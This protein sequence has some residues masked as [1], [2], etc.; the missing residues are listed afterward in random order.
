MKR[1]KML[2]GLAGAAATAPFLSILPSGAQAECPDGPKRI[3]AMSYPMGIAR[4]HWNPRGRG[5]DFTLPYCTAPLD[6]F[7]DRCLFVSNVDNKVVSLSQRYGHGQKKAGALTGTLVTEAFGSSGRHHVDNVTSLS[8]NGIGEQAKGPSIETVVGQASEGSYARRAVNLGILGQPGDRRARFD[9]AF[10]WEAEASAANLI[11]D[12]QVAFE[13]YFAGLATPDTPPDPRVIAE[14]RRRNSVLDAV[15]SHFGHFRSGLDYRDQQRLDLHAA[16][17]RQ[18]ETDIVAGGMCRPPAGIPTEPNWHAGA[19]MRDVA[20]LQI[21]ILAQSM[22]CDLAPVG[23]LEFLHQQNPFFGVPT[24][25]DHMTAAREINSRYDWHGVVHGEMDPMSGTA[26]RPSNGATG[27]HA[28]HLLDGYRFYAQ[29]FADLLRELDRFVEGPDGRTVLDNSLCVLVTDMG[30][31]TGHAP[32]KSGYVLA[33][34]LGPFRTGYHLDCAPDDRGWRDP[35]D[36]DHTHVLTTI[37][38]AFCLR[39]ASGAEVNSFGI[40]GFS[41]EGALPVRRA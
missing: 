25:D 21:R 38:N 6:E 8:G 9:S 20:N 18:L 23:R 34:N 24:V 5:T 2:K 30:D 31:G 15:R 26:T 3:I 13:E 1:R 37:A 32:F 40:E 19:S 33:G 4:Q 7:R 27:S 16:Y 36:Y 11:V 22:A 17:I 28:E 39:D 12:P 29:V 41:S 10:S 14:L 35:S